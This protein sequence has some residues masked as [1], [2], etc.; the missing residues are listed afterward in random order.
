MIQK[1]LLALVMIVSLLPLGAADNSA[2]QKIEGPVLVMKILEISDRE[3]GSYSFLTELRDGRNAITSRAVV[4]RDQEAFDKELEELTGY[5]G[6]PTRNQDDHKAW[7][8]SGD[9]DASTTTLI[10]ISP[11]SRGGPSPQSMARI[12]SLTEFNKI[13]EVFPSNY[14]VDD[15]F[16]LLNRLLK[17]HPDIKLVSVLPEELAFGK[18]KSEGHAYYL[19]R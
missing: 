15:P 18:Y 1:H 8:R 4:F 7:T 6:E 5:L 14:N 2:V 9:G 13:T 12:A 3:E 11:F 16:L 17:T 19:S 10:F